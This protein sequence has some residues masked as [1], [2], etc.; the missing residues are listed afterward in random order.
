MLCI[1]TEERLK[2]VPDT[3]S[4][5]VVSCQG[6]FVGENTSGYADVQCGR[7]NNNTP[8]YISGM[9]LGYCGTTAGILVHLSDLEHSR[10]VQLNERMSSCNGDVSAAVHSVNYVNSLDCGFGN[11]ELVI[12]TNHVPQVDDLNATIA[13]RF[14]NY[15][16]NWIRF[17][18]ALYDYHQNDQRPADLYVKPINASQIHYISQFLLQKEHFDHNT[19]LRRQ[20]SALIRPRGTGETNNIMLL[21]STN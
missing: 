11:N 4:H 5:Y 13:I 17:V 12:N 16:V 21:V 19:T 8:V 3:G 6:F 14:K 18:E 2:Y 20:M 1:I 15:P 7:R 9:V 10:Y